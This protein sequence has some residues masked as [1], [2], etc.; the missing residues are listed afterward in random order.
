MHRTLHRYARGNILGTQP[1][2]LLG[3]HEETRTGSLD[4][5]RD[6]AERVRRQETE[7]YD[8]ALR[9]R[10]LDRDKPVA[11][12]CHAAKSAGGQLENAQEDAQFRAATFDRSP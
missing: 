2:A 12:Q 7:D 1:H 4:I 8:S 11:T 5:C 6:T 10:L 3:A 9:R